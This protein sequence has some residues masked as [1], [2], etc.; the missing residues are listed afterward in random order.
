MA[1]RRQRLLR[2][3]ARLRELE[4]RAAAVAAGKALAEA[5]RQ[6][7]VAARAQALAQGTGD[8]VRPGFAQ[9][10]AGY[11]RTGPRVREIARATGQ[12]A[13]SARAN[14]DAALARQGEARRKLDRLEDHRRAL[15]IAS[16]VAG[17]KSTADLPRKAKLA[18][19]LNS[20]DTSNRETPC[21]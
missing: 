1:D 6:E 8:P 12:Q 14:A 7:R 19:I 5:Q 15:A 20:T 17:E 2:Q 11:L 9:E 13:Q 4:H 16:R 18:R 10:L 3:L 21:R